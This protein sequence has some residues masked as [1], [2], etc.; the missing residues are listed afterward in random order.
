MTFIDQPD[1]PSPG[2]DRSNK[3]KRRAERPARSKNAEDSREGGQ[4]LQ[5]E[6][7]IGL[8]GGQPATD[9]AGMDMSKYTGPES[10][11]S[12][13]LDDPEAPYHTGPGSGLSA[14]EDAHE[15]SEQNPDEEDHSF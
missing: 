1:K 9:K 12:S 10:K 13:Q 6:E 7:K 2:K 3:G 11:A 8:S 5:Q 4:S 15:E 14:Q